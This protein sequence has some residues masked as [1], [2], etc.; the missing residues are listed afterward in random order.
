MSCCVWVRHDTRNASHSRTEKENKSFRR[1][2]ENLI[3]KIMIT[4]C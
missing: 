4:K 3:G 2:S 1:L